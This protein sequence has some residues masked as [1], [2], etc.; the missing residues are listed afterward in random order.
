MRRF[1][2]LPR[3]TRPIL[4]C[5]RG[6]HLKAQLLQLLRMLRTLLIILLLMVGLFRPSVR[7]GCRHRIARLARLISF[8]SC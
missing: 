5:I 6:L 8:I 1:V 7:V 3:V 4:L 2:A